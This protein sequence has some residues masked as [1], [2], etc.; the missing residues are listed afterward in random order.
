MQGWWRKYK[1]HLSYLHFHHSSLVA[2]TILVKSMIQ[3]GRSLGRR[4]LENLVF[5][6]PKCSDKIPSTSPYMGSFPST[7]Q[8]HF[9]RKGFLPQTGSKKGPRNSIILSSNQRPASSKDHL[10]RIDW[11][12][13]SLGLFWPASQDNKS[14]SGAFFFINHTHHFQ[15]QMGLGN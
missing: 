6:P 2:L 7:E 14:G 8:C 13:I 1:P 4:S 5:K 11:P 9:I 10:G 3:L 12:D 15:I